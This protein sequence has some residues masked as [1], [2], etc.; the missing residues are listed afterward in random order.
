MGNQQA[1][2]AALP[3]VAGNKLTII[4][5]GSARS[6]TPDQAETPSRL[7]CIPHD[8]SFIVSTRHNAKP[9]T[10]RDQA[11]PITNPIGSPRL[12]RARAVG[13]GHT[14]RRERSGLSPAG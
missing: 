7:G 10:T 1:R 11:G 9:A 4:V 2:Y 3:V 8:T 14:L 6:E 5:N 13:I 12:I